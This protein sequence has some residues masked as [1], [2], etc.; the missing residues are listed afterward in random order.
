VR[1]CIAASLI[2]LWLVEGQ[3]PTRTDLIGAALAISGG[4]IIIGFA[5][6]VR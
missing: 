1:I 3:A 5:A 6:R 4:L 2:W